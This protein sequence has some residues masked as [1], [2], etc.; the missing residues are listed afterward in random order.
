V[1]SDDFWP[2]GLEK[3]LPMEKVDDHVSAAVHRA[4][5]PEGVKMRMVEA[6]LGPSCIIVR[7]EPADEGA[8]ETLLAFRDRAADEIGLRLPGHDDYKFHITLAYTRVVPTTEDEVAK[9]E[10]LKA[11]MNA[12]LGDG[13][14]F[15]TTKP[16]MAYYDDMLAFS[17]ERLPR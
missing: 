17:P 4:K 3:D 2:A 5:I 15:V 11:E 10:A 6:R 16:Y 13:I 8:K 14:E 9:K 12:V 7:L 1:R